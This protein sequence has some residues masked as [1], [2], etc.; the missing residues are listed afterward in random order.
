MWVV[1]E[2][3]NVREISKSTID[4]LIGVLELRGDT[5]AIIGLFLVFHNA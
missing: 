1:T 3:F 2:T 5:E 4:V